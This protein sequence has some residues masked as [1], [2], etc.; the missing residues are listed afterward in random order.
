MVQK[1][2]E[3][4]LTVRARAEGD[5]ERLRER[6]MPELGETIALKVSDYPF[7]A[8]ISREA[9]AQGMVKVVMDLT[10]SNF[11]DMIHK[12]PGQGHERAAVYMKIWGVLLALEPKW[13]R[14]PMWGGSQQTTM[15]FREPVESWG[16][17]R[18]DPF[19]EEFDEDVVE[20]RGARSGGER[21][22]EAYLVDHY[23]TDPDS[24]PDV[25]DEEE[26]LTAEDRQAI[27]AEFVQLQNTY[28]RE[29]VNE[30]VIDILDEQT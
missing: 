27:E 18:G 25:E 10:Y 4:L 14:Q 29:R 28:G 7:R 15:P 17:G 2:N 1:P 6:F 11:K 20:R 9:F 13:K 12:E 21:P 26:G 16:F 30:V 23:I 19:V 5:L 8:T 3:V 22:D 24:L